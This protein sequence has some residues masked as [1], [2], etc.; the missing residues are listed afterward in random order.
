MLWYRDSGHSFV[1]W[2][3]GSLRISIMNLINLIHIFHRGC[4][5]LHYLLRVNPMYWWGSTRLQV[6]SSHPILSFD[7]DNKRERKRRIRIKITPATTASELSTAMVCLRE[8]NQQLLEDF[9]CDL[10]YYRRPRSH[11]HKVRWWLRKLLVWMMMRL[12]TILSS[13]IIIL[14]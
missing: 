8:T 11:N 1:L 7:D 4:L 5:C 13:V 14:T 2:Q 9:Q 12:K 3:E 6:V 10:V